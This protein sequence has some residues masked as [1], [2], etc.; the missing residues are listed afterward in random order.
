[1]SVIYN[2]T[3]SSDSNAALQETRNHPQVLQA[4]LEDDQLRAIYSTLLSKFT[5]P[6]TPNIE[7]SALINTNQCLT[8][9]QFDQ[10]ISVLKPEFPWDPMEAFKF[11]H[12]LRRLKNSTSAVKF[13][14][15]F[16][17]SPKLKVW[18][19]AR[20]SRLIVVKGKQC[21]QKLI[22]HF[23]TLVIDQLMTYN[24]PVLWAL[25][26]PNEEGTRISCREISGNYLLKLLALQAIN[27]SSEKRTE[28]SIS[29]L[30]HRFR[31]ATSE[32]S[33]FDIL[34]SIL[35]GIGPLVYIVV[36]TGLLDGNPDH[37]RGFPWLQSFQNLLHK[38]SSKFPGP[39]VKILLLHCR[40]DEMLEPSGEL[41]PD[42]VVSAGGSFIPVRGRKTMRRN[43]SYPVNSSLIST[44]LYPSDSA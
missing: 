10:A 32:N 17:V 15:R 44:C 33:W 39:E 22:R 14:D 5:A 6:E 9:M 2:A 29:L 38:L 1:M 40:S 20:G 28:K 7:T 23:S 34:G 12:S 31:T 3:N 37:L 41:P 43:T 16:W 27:I 36:D 11:H 42:I 35:M 21:A 4:V 24:V 13:S 30:H 8:E 25:P 19:S 18:S 26:M